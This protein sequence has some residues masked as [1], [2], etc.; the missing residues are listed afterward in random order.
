MTIKEHLSWTYEKLFHLNK[1]VYLGYNVGKGSRMYGTLSRIPS[2]GYNEMPC[3]ENL[4]AGVG[5]GLALEGSRL[6]VLCFERHEFVLFGMGILAAFA[7]KLHLVT[8]NVR[9][10]MV[11]RVIKGAEKPLYPGAQHCG[12]YTNTILSALPNSS[13]L[14]GDSR[15]TYED[16]IQSLDD[17]ASGIVI[18]LEDKDEYE[19]QI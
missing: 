6:P 11:V 15:L 17:S 4:I 3:A 13:L 14:C 10:P 12:D 16:I 9:V 5:V 8:S 2:E 7:D 18:I 1:A 19:Q